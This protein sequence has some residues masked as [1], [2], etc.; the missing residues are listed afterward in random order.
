MSITRKVQ[1]VFSNLGDNSYKQWKAELH[2]DGRVVSFWSAVGSTEQ[3]KDYGCVGEAFLEKKIREK[4]KK[5]YEHAKVVIDGPVAAT[6]AVPKGSLADIALSQI[7]FS[8]DLIKQLIRRLADSNVHKIMSATSISYNSVS[9]LFQ[10]PLGVVTS[11]GIDAA[12]NLLAFFNGKTNINAEYKK[13]IDQYL[14][15][16]PRNKGSRL[17]YEHI[18]PDL[19]AI[20]KESDV[21]D[22]LQN[23][24]DLISK[25]IVAPTATPTKVE[26]VFN[27][28]LDR[29]DDDK[30]RGRIE[31]WYEG[32]KKSMHHYDRVKIRDI[33]VIDIVD[34]NKNFDD[35]LGNNVQ[36]WH[37]SSQSNILSIA[38]VGLKVSPPSTAAIAGKMFGNGVYGS[39]TSSKSLG[40]TLGR[41][42]QTSGDSGW[43]F[44]C[45]FAMG[46]AFYPRG[47]TSRIPSGH[48]SCWALPKNTGL[49]NDELIVYSEKQIRV[50]Y[51]LEVK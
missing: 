38:K 17:S 20:Q 7:K 6:S 5:G 11:E 23:S 4:I 40:Y 28:K 36:V 45:D 24:L 1:L 30:E 37:G 21:L 8:N 3:T 49:H 41:W 39:E 16:I 51:L 50:K 27:L 47:A 43:L 18:F 13:N 14:R 32:T 12:R 15:L 48:D 25:P 19:Q 26:Q 33:Y 10:S 31:K 22:A 29:L 46:N 2:D 35:R 9:G 42:G 44:I 34:Y